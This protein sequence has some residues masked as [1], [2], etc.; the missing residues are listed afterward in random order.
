MTDPKR[1]QLRAETMLPVE[2]L[3]RIGVLAKH[4]AAY[5]LGR[6]MLIAH[7][8]SNPRTTEMA[9]VH[10]VELLRAEVQHI[11]EKLA[12]H[13]DLLSQDRRTDRPGWGG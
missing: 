13:P 7:A 5:Y 10:A 9:H 2:Q 12:N 8:A 11:Q 3:E 4:E 1:E 6:L